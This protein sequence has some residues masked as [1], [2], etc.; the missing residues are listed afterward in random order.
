MPQKEEQVKLLIFAI[1]S[2][3]IILNLRVTVIFTIASVL[4]LYLI[5]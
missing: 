2:A 3:G 4:R 1:R 5:T